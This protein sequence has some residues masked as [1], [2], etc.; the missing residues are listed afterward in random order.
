MLSFIIGCAV[1]A[2]A[3]M[4]FGLAHLQSDIQIIIALVGF[5]GGSILAG[6]AWLIMLADRETDDPP[7]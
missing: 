2:Y 5:I 6:I 4:L 3:A 7:A 1:L